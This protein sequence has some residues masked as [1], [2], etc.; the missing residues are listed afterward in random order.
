MLP[1]SRREF[2]AGVSLAFLAGGA[3]TPAVQ[4]HWRSTTFQ[5]SP[6]PGNSA[7]M[8]AASKEITE[9]SG[10][11]LQ[12]NFY[13]GNTLPINVYD[14]A[15]AC[16][17][18]EVQ[19]ADE[20]FFMNQCIGGGLVSLPMLMDNY[21]EYYRAM[22]IVE[23]SIVRAYAALGCEVLGRYDFS[24]VYIF[25]SGKTPITSLADLRGRRIRTGRVVHNEFLSLCGAVTTLI[26]TPDVITAFRA[27]T[28]DGAVT[29]FGAGGDIWRE[30]ITSVFLMRI[31][32]AQGFFIVNRAAMEALPQSQR[33][34]I[35]KLFRAEAHNTTAI[36]RADEQEVIDW[37]KRKGMVSTEMSESE[38]REARAK[39]A[40][41]W[42]KWAR[43]QGPEAVELLAKVRAELG[44]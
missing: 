5:G 39:A 12:I 42:E 11:S 20:I 4:R 3:A 17:R 41:V 43:A 26:V 29:S 31:Y 34:H 16:G 6:V 13:L 24:P 8:Q 38:K 28:I 40:I 22:A 7:R 10:G 2:V 9:W 25:G 44:R 35:R 15:K 19:L 36:M 32:N 1:L 33:Q 30:Y 14:L 23:P 37:L 21:D 18:G 27:G